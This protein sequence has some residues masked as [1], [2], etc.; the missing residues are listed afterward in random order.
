MTAAENRA[1]PSTGLRNPLV[2]MVLDEV[3]AVYVR[4]LTARLVLLE[5]RDIQLRTR[6][7]IATGEAWDSENFA[8][9]SADQIQE[10]IAESMVRGLGITRLEALK[11]VR[12]NYA[13]SNPS[14]A[15][16][17]DEPVEPVAVNEVPPA[18]TIITQGPTP[19]LDTPIAPPPAQG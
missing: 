16:S 9:M 4:K 5:L 10:E 18:P 12:E 19:D 13:T 14:T 15:K 8:D 6:L 1:R 2:G 7:E 11:R 17:A 3:A